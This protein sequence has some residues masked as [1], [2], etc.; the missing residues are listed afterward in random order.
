M[1]APQTLTTL[2]QALADPKLLG[3]SLGDLSSWK[4]WLTILKAAFAEPLDKEERELFA[5]I[6]GGRGVPTERV[7]ELWVVAG[8]RG[9]KTRIAGALSVHATTMQKHPLAPGERGRALTL[10]V[11]KDQAGACREYARG[12]LRTSPILSKSII[13]DSAERITLKGGL[14]II[15]HASNFRSV[16]GGTLVL[17]VFDECSFW[18]DENAA[19]P[20][21]EVYR[22]IRPSLVTTG[23]MLIGISSPYRRTGLL[24][25]KYAKYFGQDDPAVLVIKAPTT[26]L[27]PTIPK[28]EIERAMQD[29]PE[30]ARAEWLAE[31]RDDIAGY[32]DRKAV[33]ACVAS[34]VRERQPSFA[35]RYVGF[36]DP[37]GGRSDSMTLAIAH[38]EGETAILDAV[39]EVK[40]PFNPEAVV[41]EFCELVKSYRLASVWGDKYASEWVQ[42]RFRSEGINYKETDK[43]KSE[44][45]VDLLPAL[46]SAAVSLLDNDRLINQFVGLERRTTRGGRRVDTIDH[47]PGAHDDLAN[48]AAGALVYAGRSGRFRRRASPP[49]VIL[50]YAATKRKLRQKPK[51][52]R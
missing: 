1:K 42:S 26:T 43:A 23:G 9:G 22:A 48:A 2:S 10:A 38:H 11:S 51:G 19:H 39:R 50:G 40:P 27:N 7:R 36:V 8:R 5:S 47:A 41:S 49:K 24:Y 21:I 12:F 52:Q 3:A 37:S 18:R 34:E 25:E 33:E 6:S 28:E 44:I 29:D 35:H 13:E 17:C 46:N 30:A 31:F 32:V 14:E 4:A 45:Y 16:R 15:A 20:D